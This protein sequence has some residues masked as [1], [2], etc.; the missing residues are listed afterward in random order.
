[1]KLTHQHQDLKYKDNEEKAKKMDLMRKECDTSLQGIK[2]L[3]EPSLELEK[4]VAGFLEL[5]LRSKHDDNPW[6]E[7]VIPKD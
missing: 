3:N 2:L 6:S 7:R 5:R 4:S 1:M